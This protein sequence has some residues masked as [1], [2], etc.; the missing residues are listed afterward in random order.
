MKIKLS[1]LFITLAHLACGQIE[2]KISENKQEY[3]IGAEYFAGWW[4]EKPNKWTA[5]DGSDWR[6][7][8]PERMPL[9]GQNNSQEVMD[10]DILSASKNGIDFFSILWYYDRGN[11]GTSKI[12]RAI[13]WFV[14]SP[15]NNK[16]KFMFE[17][18]NHKPFIVSTDKQWD[19]VAR[20][21]AKYMQHPSYLRVDGRAVFKIHG[22]GAFLQDQGN[23]PVK[24][25]KVLD[26]LRT[27]IKEYGGGDVLIALGL[28]ED[29]KVKNTALK[30]LNFDCAMQYADVTK[31]PRT[32][33]D[34]PYPLLT[35][36]ACRDYA[37]RT[38]DIVPY[39]PFV[40]TGWCPK[41]WGDPRANFTSPTE[42]E[43]ENALKAAK[44]ALDTY[45]NMGF[46]FRDGRLQKAL[47]IYAWNEYGEGGYLAPSVGTGYM[48]LET[49]KKIFNK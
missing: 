13:E 30:R 48:K 45:P 20:L 38:D 5:P 46:P 44:H 9:N 37:A 4:E 31:L 22:G 41:A 1:I 12:N 8:Y 35:E 26:N 11:S 25:Q 19:D 40:M 6:L 21:C 36:Q 7:D 49:V 29:V 10:K 2:D 15:H 42:K 47:T 18:V 43:W 14:N 16:M 3:I 27:K 17:L 23:D 32:E 28:T 33:E 39:V 24:A 34:Y